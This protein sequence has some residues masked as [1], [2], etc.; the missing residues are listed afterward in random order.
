MLFPWPKC[1]ERLLEEPDYET[2]R[3]YIV[4]QATPFAKGVACETRR[5]SA[6]MGAAKFHWSVCSP[7]RVQRRTSLVPSPMRPQGV[8]KNL[9][10]DWGFVTDALK[11]NVPKQLE[12]Q[13][14]W[15]LHRLF[16]SRIVSLYIKGQVYS[17]F[18]AAGSHALHKLN[19][20]AKPGHSLHKRCGSHA[21]ISRAFGLFFA[22]VCVWYLVSLATPFPERG[23]PATT[24][25]SPRNAIIEHSNKMLISSF[26]RRGNLM[27]AAWPD[28]PSL[29]EG[30]GL[31]GYMISPWTFC[32]YVK[33][34][35]L[36][37]C[38][39]ILKVSKHG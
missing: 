9:V 33:F 12:V 34:Y 17:L 14:S 37:L 31:G 15:P 7:F 23:L 30:C 5:Y 24:E 11:E 6:G 10:W 16:D 21:Q 36:N 3:R 35:L 39:S 27:V 38:T 1:I 28:P 25:L 29:C 18:F 22:C 13:A 32:Q 2:W 20:R 4:S 8:R 19:V 26:C